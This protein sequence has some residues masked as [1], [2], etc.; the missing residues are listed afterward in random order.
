MAN[1]NKELLRQ[2]RVLKPKLEHWEVAPER[3]VAFAADSTAWQGYAAIGIGPAAG[4]LNRPF[5]AGE[6]FLLDF[7]EHS[8]GRLKLAMRTTGKPADAPVRLKLLFAELP[9][10]IAEAHQ[11]GDFHR[12]NHRAQH[13]CH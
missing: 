3:Q 1:C 2:V 4:V 13:R 12:I 8:V 7:G 10:E 9:Q 5:A 6:R 11:S